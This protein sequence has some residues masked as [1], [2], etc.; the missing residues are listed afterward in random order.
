MKN[1]LI[2]ALI[3]IIFFSCS[4]EKATEI[5]QEMGSR[6]EDSGSSSDEREKIAKG[7]A[8]FSVSVS[9]DGKE[10]D[11]S[12]INTEDNIVFMNNALNLKL[13]DENQNVC[14]VNLLG[15]GVYESTPNSFTLQNSEL[16]QE[17]QM[18]SKKK[19]SHVEV[20]WPQTNTQYDKKILYSGE[21]TLEKL[22]DDIIEI[23]FTGEGIDYGRSPNKGP[24]YPMTG[25][26]RLENYNSYDIR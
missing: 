14:M 10:M 3:G 9:I 8:N 21:V 13:V 17:E 18:T 11:F 1:T 26:I 5:T 12:A 23:S 25:K 16:S 22:T 6:V 15:E 20:Y 19:R 24:F 4:G 7:E 2:L